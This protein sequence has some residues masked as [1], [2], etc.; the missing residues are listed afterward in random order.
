M[1]LRGMRLSMATC[2][3]YLA[4]LQHFSFR[5]GF[6][7]KVVGMHSLG[8]CCAAS[9]VPRPTAS[10]GRLGNLSVATLILLHAYI[11][12]HFPAHDAIM[13]LVAI[14]SAFLGLLRFAGYCSPS[15]RHFDL[16]IHLQYSDLTLDT[17]RGV[18]VGGGASVCLC[19][20][21]SILSLHCVTSVTSVAWHTPH[22]RRPIVH[23]PGWVILDPGPLGAH[24]PRGI[25]FLIQP[26]HPLL[27]HR[28]RVCCG[29]HG[30]L[31]SHDP[32]PRAVAERLLQ[33]LRTAPLQICV[34][35]P[36]PRVEVFGVTRGTPPPP[37]PPPS[38]VTGVRLALSGVNQG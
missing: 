20:T 36:A 4:G 29:C 15:Q 23:I 5:F 30:L 14:F 6:P 24:P 34:P 10:R 9:N 1:A 2:C 8:L 33:A 31:L 27:P 7:M 16:G 19:R 12:R 28:G 22:L 21:S 32:G 11:H 35:R 13:L 25:P 17:E 18:G 38:A 3:T 37:P 26:E